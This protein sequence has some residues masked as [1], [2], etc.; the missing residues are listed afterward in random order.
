[1][2]KIS[3]AVQAAVVLII[4]LQVAGCGPASTRE[5]GTPPPE[6]TDSALDVKKLTGVLLI[7]PV[8]GKDN[9]PSDYWVYIDKTMML[10]RVSPETDSRSYDLIALQLIPGSYKLESA[11]YVVPRGP[12]FPFAFSPQTVT[13]REGDTTSIEVSVDESMQ[14]G[15]LVGGYPVNGAWQEW[16]DSLRAG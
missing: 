3:T 5:A 10:N 12:S 16:Y 7:K 4:M 1:M 11:V 14:G 2:R 13:I 8:C 6:A 15:M 9:H